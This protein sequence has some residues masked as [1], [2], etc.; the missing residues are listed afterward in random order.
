[1]LKSD[2]LQPNSYSDKIRIE[3]LR[4]LELML[5]SISSLAERENSES[6]D[7]IPGNSKVITYYSGAES[8]HP[9]SSTSEVKTIDFKTGPNIMFTQT[10]TYDA[11][12][13][14]LTIS[15]T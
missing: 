9:S 5:I 11:D 13:N 15:T 7:T 10:L 3:I 6:W 14:V 8:G 12:N 1:M 2:K 4:E